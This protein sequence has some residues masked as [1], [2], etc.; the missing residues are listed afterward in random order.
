MGCAFD[1][2]TPSWNYRSYVTALVIGFYLIPLFVIF[3]SYIGIIQSSRKSMKTL[4]RTESVR[5]S[6]KNMNFS[7]G[8]KLKTAQSISN[9]YRM[10]SS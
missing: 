6:S 3:G 8:Q 9:E 4:V 1:F 10:V 2:Y 7:N 5:T